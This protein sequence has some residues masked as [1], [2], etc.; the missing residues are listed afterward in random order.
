M[1]YIKFREQLEKLTNDNIHG[2]SYL[3]QNLYNLF[4][5][6]SNNL[7]KSEYRKLVHQLR[8]WHPPMGNILNAIPIIEDSIDESSVNLLVDFS[9]AESDR[10]SLLVKTI[11]RAA[12]ELFKYDTVATISNSGSVA[13]GVILAGKQGWTGTLLIGES[14]PAMEGKEMAITLNKSLRGYKIIIGTDN[15]IL[16]AIPKVDAV[17]VGADLVSD[18]YFINKAGTA[19]MARALSSF[20]TMYVVA[21]SSKY[22]QISA[23]DIEIPERPARE[24]WPKHPRGIEVINHYFEIIEFQSNIRFINELGIWDS[25]EIKNYLDKSGDSR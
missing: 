8:S 3:C 13:G 7:R 9:I 21:D 6:A 1:S 23:E 19:G 2:A 17:F 20:R 18:S 25:A 4:S 24:I 22:F 5:D 11:E 12:E 14:R 16:S 10:E 15:E